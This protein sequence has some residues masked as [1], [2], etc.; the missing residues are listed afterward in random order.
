MAAIKIIEGI[1][2]SETSIEDAIKHALSCTHKTVRNV[3]GIDVIGLTAKVEN[4]KIVRWNANVKI[5][6]EVER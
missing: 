5:A 6:F 4:G 3:T 2:T 1:G